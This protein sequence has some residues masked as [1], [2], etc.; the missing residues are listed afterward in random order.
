MDGLVT[1]TSIGTATSRS[2]FWIG[3]STAGSDASGAGDGT[4]DGDMGSVAR[5]SAT[6]EGRVA[7]GGS[8]GGGTLC[9]IAGALGETSLAP[10][11][12]APSRRG[13]A[14]G[15]RRGSVG[16]SP[17]GTRAT[18]P[19]GIGSRSVAAG[20]GVRV[21]GGSTARGGWTMPGCWLIGGVDVRETGKS[22][23]TNEPA[24]NA[25]AARESVIASGRTRS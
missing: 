25:H 11:A 10:F 16:G 12:L 4:G 17:C 21:A 14:G 6:G 1:G 9:E 8:T 22:L 5:L 3:D 2:G 7:G 20:A 18:D 15:S 23:G 24:R 13:S 19:A